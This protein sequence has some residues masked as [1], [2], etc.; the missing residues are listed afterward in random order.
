MSV[1]R[2]VILALLLTLAATGGAAYQA[3]A[4]TESGSATSSLRL[5]CP[6]H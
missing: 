2:H 3:S 4:V 5:V 1:R 6:L